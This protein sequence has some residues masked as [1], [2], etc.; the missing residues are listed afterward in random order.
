MDSRLEQLTE[1]GR[2]RRC[3]IRY[4]SLLPVFIGF[5][6]GVLIL[7]RRELGTIVLLCGLILDERLNAVLKAAIQE[8]RPARPGDG[9]EASGADPTHKVWGEHGMP[10]SHT[11]FMFFFASYLTLWVCFRLRPRPTAYVGERG[12]VVLQGAVVVGVFALAGVVGYSRVYL[13]YHTP[14]QVLVG[15]L[16]GTVS[17]TGWY[18]LMATVLAPWF[19]AV[20]E[21]GIS[22][23]L[24]LRDSSPLDDVFLLEYNATRAAKRKPKEQ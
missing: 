1:C 9:A 22:R 21:W 5:G 2:R 8:P 10:S 7:A 14:A 15:C 11:Q 16:V 13:V 12:L 6:L 19:G 24:L 20:E 23:L 4:I 17:G 18:A 3:G